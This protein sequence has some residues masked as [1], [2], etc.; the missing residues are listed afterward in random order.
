MA[1]GTAVILSMD[2]NTLN[3]IL[4][5]GNSNLS[6]TISVCD[7]RAFAENIAHSTSRNL[8]DEIVTA[9]KEAMGDKALYCNTQ[10]AKEIL[11][12]AQSTLNLWMKKGIITPCKI[13]R[14]NL[15]LRSDILAYKNKCDKAKLA[16]KSHSK[17]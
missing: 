12:C 7:L 13:G 16:K 9:V 15:F 11:E 3:R 1:A 6:L 14:P 10:E 17:Q 2:E 5:D 4:Q 8:A